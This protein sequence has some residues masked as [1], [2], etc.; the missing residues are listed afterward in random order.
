[1]KYYTTTPNGFKIKDFDL[2][3]T[4][5]SAQPLTFF[6]DYNFGEGIIEYPSGRNFIKATILGNSKSVQARVDATDLDT[7]KKDFMIRFGLNDNMQDI[8]KHIDTDKFVHAAIEKYHGMRVTVNDPWEAT[9]CFIMSQYNNIKRIRL[10][11]KNFVKAFG[12]E[13]VAD[14]GIILGRT[15]PTSEELMKFP[16]SD[17]RAAGAGFRAKYIKEAAEYCTNNLDLYKLKNKSYDKLKEELMTITGVGDKVADCIA[18]MGYGNMQAFPIDVWVK[19]T[20]EGM[21]FNGKP[22]K[23]KDLHKFAEERWGASYMGYAQQYIFHS[24]RNL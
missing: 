15:F 1:M 23:I 3:H 8:Y 20:L 24:G 11:V 17:F 6:A 21:Y 12:N 13:I 9:L 22:Q 16:E 5:E 4:I 18:L 2:A 10:I 14:D 7:A 19:R